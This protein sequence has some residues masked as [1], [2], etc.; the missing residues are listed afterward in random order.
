M[1]IQRADADTGAPLGP[2][3]RAA[4]TV[5]FVAPKAGYR[6]PAAAAWLG[7][8]HVVDIGV[9]ASFGP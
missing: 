7:R 1:S 2:T 4:H 6:N 5:T 9:A 3:I 8:V